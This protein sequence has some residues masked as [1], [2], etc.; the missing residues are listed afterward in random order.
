LAPEDWCGVPLSDLS[1]GAPTL[2][3]DRRAIANFIVDARLRA[4]ANVNSTATKILIYGYPAWS[5]GRVYYDLCKYL[6]RCGYIVD[7]INWQVSHA[8]YMDQL[9]SYYDF[10]ISALDGMRTLLEVYRVPA[11][12]VIGLSH[13]EVDIQ[14]LIEQMGRG[15]FERLA[16]YGVVSYQLYDASTIFGVPRHPLVVQLG[17][18]SDEF[19]MEI[20]ERLATVGYAG[21]Y[22]HKTPAGIEWKRGEIAEAAAREAGL[23][24][25][26]AGWTGNQISFHDMPEFYRSV[27]AI[28]VSSVNEGAGLPFK[29]GAAAGRLVIS[30]PVGDFPL[31]ASQGLGIVAPIENHKY[32][33][34][35][36]ETLLYYKDNPA[37]FSEICRKTQTAAQKLD[38][39]NVIGDW[40]ELIETAKTYRLAV[41]AP[42]DAR[43]LVEAGPSSASLVQW[44]GGNARQMR[45]MLVDRLWRGNDPLHH[46]PGNLFEYDLQ[47]WNSQ[48][49]YLAE[50]ITEL[51]PPAI[52]EIGVWKGGSTIFMANEAKSLGLDSVVVA[53]DTWLGSSEHW[54]T[55]NFAQ[56]SFL[57]GYPALYYKFLSNVIRAGVTKYILPIPVD[58]LNAAEI[59]KS[60]GFKPWIIHLDGGHDYESVTADLRAWWP[61]LVN[62]GLFIGDDYFTTGMWIDVKRAFDDFFRPLNLLPLEN[63]NG[64]CRIRKPS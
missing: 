59:L 64:K 50:A 29:E 56:M 51:R 18:D 40:V 44:S 7:I 55:D 32:K 37:A 6:Y 19:R 24:F 31:W 13:H 41:A 62:G 14:I 61:L 8:S 47:G 25:K 16:G 60:L 43:E 28:L 1:N 9:I 23:E 45:Q 26:S 4:K 33:K 5:H 21:S 12:K 11:E 35:V 10:F 48:H 15:V 36:T 3:I 42:R 2:A 49:S 17:V 53:V 22:T 34:F 52:V 27:D 63:M 46:F 20:P 54:L 57:N 38:W 39:P 30:T 58:S